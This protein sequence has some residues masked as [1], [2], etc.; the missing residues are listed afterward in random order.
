MAANSDT[1]DFDPSIGSL[2]QRGKKSSTSKSPQKPSYRGGGK[3]TYIPVEYR[4]LREKQSAF[5]KPTK[6]EMHAGAI[7]HEEL[8]YGEFVRERNF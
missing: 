1:G 7:N 4:H 3:S 2:S 8:E 6:V 5:A